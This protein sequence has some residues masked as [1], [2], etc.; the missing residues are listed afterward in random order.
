M[1]GLIKIEEQV[2]ELQIR[3]EDRAICEKELPAALVEFKKLMSEAGHE[4][5]PKVTINDAPLPSKSM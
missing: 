3:A 5:D 2:V 1:Q 4:V